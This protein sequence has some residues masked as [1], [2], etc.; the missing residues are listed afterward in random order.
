MFHSL[1]L[2]VVNTMNQ[3]VLQV[4]KP[5]KKL[6][7]GLRHTEFQSS[8]LLERKS[9][10]RDSSKN[11]WVHKTVRLM[12]A[13][14]SY[15]D[16]LLED[17]HQCLLRSENKMYSRLPSVLILH[18]LFTKMMFWTINSLVNGQFVLSCHLSLYLSILNKYLVSNFPA[19]IPMRDWSKEWLKLYQIQR[20]RYK[21]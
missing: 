13:K 2:M 9:K 8:N 15:V 12:P 3:M 19:R 21:P 5:W 7:S 17:G 1:M 6:E 4:P 11:C 16:T 20:T 18:G 10:R 14:C